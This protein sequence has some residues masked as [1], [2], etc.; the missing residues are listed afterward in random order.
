MAIVNLYF[1]GALFAFG[2]FLYCQHEEHLS[3]IGSCIK[4]HSE[5]RTDEES[6]HGEAVQ[7]ESV[8]G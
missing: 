6:V 5:E 7:D 2:W 3:G 1:F 8:L 4:C